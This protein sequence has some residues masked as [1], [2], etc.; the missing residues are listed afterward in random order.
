MR[1]SSSSRPSAGLVAGA[2]LGHEKL[3]D[4]IGRGHRWPQLLTI[5]SRRAFV[6][7]DDGYD[8]TRMALNTGLVAS[9]FYQSLAFPLQDGLPIRPTQD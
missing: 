5:A 9:S 2:G 6:R 3:E 8:S 4:R 1:Y 7:L